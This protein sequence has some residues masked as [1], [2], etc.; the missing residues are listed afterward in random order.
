MGTVQHYLP[1]WAIWSQLGLTALASIATTS[2]VVIYGF[3]QLRLAREKLRHDLYGKRYDIYHSAQKLLV[4]YWRGKIT[5]A[6][7]SD[8]ALSL[9]QSKFLLDSGLDRTLDHLHQL[10]F[11]AFVYENRQQ[12]VFE[13][14][15]SEERFRQHAEDQMKI[16]AIS[17]SLPEL[18]RPYLTLED[19]SQNR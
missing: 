13:G 4:L 5:Q 12:P 3:W 11:K 9:G 2:A 15:G 8:A 19:F 14:P 18:F 1:E 16:T 6:D 7:I 10:V 17:I